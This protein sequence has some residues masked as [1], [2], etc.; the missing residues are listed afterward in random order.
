MKKRIF[1]FIIDLLIISLINELLFNS[2]FSGYSISTNLFNIL[3]I[4]ITPIYLGLISFYF[5]IIE[6]LFKRSLGKMI[7]N[8]HIYIQGSDDRVPFITLFMRGLVKSLT[9]TF[10][11]GIFYYIYKKF[12]STVHDKLFRT[13]V[14]V[15]RNKLSVIQLLA[16]GLVIGISLLNFNFNN[17][18]F[19]DTLVKDV[20]IKNLNGESFNLLNNNPIFINVFTTWCKPCINE[21]P[22]LAQLNDALQR[23]EIDFYAISPEN[24][25]KIVILREKIKPQFE[26]Y[27]GKDNELI[28]SISIFPTSLLINKMGEIVWTQ[29][30]TIDN[31]NIDSLV[32]IFYDKVSD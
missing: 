11:V 27:S 30:G 26:L 18:P 9:F 12:S 6:S 15:E 20:S 23:V 28:N 19:N 3:T 32:K 21:F 4:K 14:T 2:F 24:I 22:Y 16:I 1:S 13:S 17:N 25:Q 5:A 31:H 8:L 7:F 29:R 10:L